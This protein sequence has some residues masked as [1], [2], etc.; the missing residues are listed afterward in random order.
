MST[1][2]AAR[3]RAGS[4]ARTDEIC[5]GRKRREPDLERQVVGIAVVNGLL[6]R[7]DADDGDD[8]AEWFLPRQPHVL[9][10]VV[11]EKRPD[12][13]ALW[14]HIQHFTC[15]SPQENTR[16]VRAA[17]RPID[18]T[19][20]WRQRYAFDELDSCFEPCFTGDCLIEAVQPST[21]AARWLKEL[22]YTK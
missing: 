9:G 3:Q 22:A 14:T 6:H 13:V 12:K 21:P 15:T 10:H 4:G 5:P 8:G 7:L 1:R 2:L 20:G 17:L 19:E 11:D 18:S 16:P